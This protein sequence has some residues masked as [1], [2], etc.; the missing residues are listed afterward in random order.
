[1]KQYFL[2][3]S[4]TL[5]ASII[6]VQFGKAQINF[7]EMPQPND[8]A[9]TD[10]YKSPTG[11][12][13]IKTLFRGKYI[14]TS[15]DGANWQK[16]Y[17]SDSNKYYDLDKMYFFEDGTPLIKD[18]Y[19]GVLIRRDNEW[20]TMSFNNNSWE[21]IEA[22]HI[23]EDTLFAYEDNRFAY[24]VDKGENFVPLFTADENITD[25]SSDLFKI[26]N[27]FYLFHTAGATGKVSIFNE[28][29]VRLYF[30]NINTT[31]I[32]NSAC[33][34][35]LF[36]RNTNYIFIT[37]NGSSLT[38]G[39]IS[40]ITP[41][42][43][44]RNL[45]FGPNYFYAIDNDMIY[46][47]SYCPIEWEVIGETS[48]VLPEGSFS[49]N[50][51]GDLFVINNDN[52]TINENND[53]SGDWDIIPIEI[54][55]P[56]ITGM[57][58][59]SNDIQ[60]CQTYNDR[61]FAKSQSE[62]EWQKVN[63][64]DSVYALSIRY[65]AYGRVYGHA[66]T[67]IVY[68]H[69]FGQSYEEISLANILSFPSIG[70]CRIL[71][72]N[73]IYV[74]S[75]G[76]IYLSF[77]NG[78]SWVQAE[79]ENHIGDF[80]KVVEKHGDYIY[81][82]EYDFGLELFTYHIPTGI[83]STTFVE[84]SSLFLI[85]IPPIL[86]SDGTM[87]FTDDNPNSYDIDLRR[88]NP[89]GS[90]ETVI[91]SFWSFIKNTSND[92]IYLFDDSDTFMVTSDF[93][94]LVEGA[95]IGINTEGFRTYYISDNDYLFV[96]VDNSII[97]RSTKPLTYQAAV[98]GIVFLE[99]TENCLYEEELGLQAWNITVENEN[100]SRSRVTNS[101]G[102]FDISLP[103]GTYTLKPHPVN[104]YY[105]LCA[106]AY[107]I[108][109]ED[110]M[111][112]VQHIPTKI[113][114]ECADL[115]IDFSTPFLR[116]CFDNNYYFNL[117]NKGPVASE[118]SE[119]FVQMDS[120][121]DLLTVSENYESLP[122]NTIKLSIP[123]MEVNECIQ[124]NIYFN[125]SCDADMGQEHCLEAWVETDNL[126]SDARSNFIECQ[127]NIGSWD[128]NDKRAFNESGQE[129]DSVDKEEVI[130]YHI[131]F[132]N[133]GTD[134]AFNIL[135]TD[136]ISPLL[137]L[138]TFEM[139]SSSH[140]NSYEINDGRELRVSFPNIL[141]PDSTTNEPASH[142]YFKFKIIPYPNLA[143]ETI[144][145]NEAAIYFDFN[146]AVI[147]NLH[148]TKIRK[149]V[150]IK[151][152]LPKID[153]KIFPNPTNQVLNIDLRNQQIPKDAYWTI[154]N[155][156]GQKLIEK[157]VHSKNNNINLGKLPQGLYYISLIT[158]NQIVATQQFV[159]W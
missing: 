2:P 90:L 95:L 22:V 41:T 141:L 134:T 57:E 85:S 86:L 102:E 19:E 93:S 35:L 30:Y 146:E 145:S 151:E 83:T 159:K 139:L 140:E 123:A 45:Y 124:F 15:S 58:E 37:N 149:P 11:E 81:I 135:V 32:V 111:T 44:E 47:S 150:S 116:R 77:D 130:L 97:Y 75:L 127:E 7:L 78:N 158:Q 108:I 69:N 100:F 66:N 25:H 104:D 52:Y 28:S 5:L 23:K 56:Y 9:A 148:Q 119:I 128:P 31:N 20:T 21:R 3:L 155:M 91:S 55:D 138:S 109:V 136:I 1:M 27:L 8:I 126:C 101:A 54:T 144:I 74:E 50:T 114:L 94:S 33:D 40:D 39:K 64:P 99:E 133:T 80:S 68:T 156:L 17:L 110:S 125:L 79:F 87:Y 132:Q 92:E 14:F 118:S 13:F 106:E 38:S 115:Q 46:K 24:S 63:F 16:E 154:R 122:D 49:V 96:V 76:D 129:V 73:T 105:D 62:Q 60:F 137:D 70:D 36:F 48:S 147:T 152:I 42:D 121:F 113:N 43:D 82:I 65:D 131:R 103:V 153:F 6:F 29:G 12:Y 34:E 98:N 71:D 157:K 89:D 18:F 4:F 67:T 117:C 61:I 143:Y 59:F 51:N 84:I 53:L 107:S 112:I 26:G 120:F 72:E 88:R 10:V 142:G